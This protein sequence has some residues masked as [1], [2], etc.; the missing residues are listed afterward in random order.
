MSREQRYAVWAVVLGKTDSPLYYA[1]PGATVGA[2]AVHLAAVGLTLWSVLSLGLTALA[3]LGAV[4]HYL[5][6]GQAPK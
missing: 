3:V 5:A 6:E 1:L 4:T 2:S